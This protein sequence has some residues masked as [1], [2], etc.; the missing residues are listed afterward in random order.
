MKKYIE[1]IYRIVF[2]IISGI[3]IGIHFNINDG[4]YNAHE[5]SFFTI[6]SNIFCFVMM[7]ILLI[8]YFAGKD[9]NSKALMYFKG[10]SLSAILCTFLVYHFAECRFKYPIYTTGLIGI[11]LKSFLAHYVVPFMFILD[12][13][14]FQPKG[15]FKWWHIFGWLAFPLMYFL[16]FITR[17]GCNDAS[18]F[19]NVEKYPY[20]F[21]DYETLGVTTFCKYILV[22]LVIMISLN[23]L[24]I[25][26]D[27]FMFRIS[28]KRN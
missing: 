11:P 28:K 19:T 20:Y 18:A 2:I 24:I 13:I 16:C 17:C 10:M 6:Q 9:I 22:M 21:L 15:Y 14:I 23:I 26:L 25:L 8:K 12:W 27:K 7:C 4:D 5:F 3:G 1:L